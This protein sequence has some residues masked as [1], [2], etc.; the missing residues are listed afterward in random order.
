MPKDI[1][2]LNWDYDFNGL[3]IPRTAEIAESGLPFMVCPGTNGWLTHGTNLPNAIG[4][5]SQFA[6]AGRKWGAEGLLNTDWGDCGH[7][8]TLGVSLHGFAHGAAHSWNGRGVDDKTFTRTFCFH[9]FGQRDGKLAKAVE[10]LGSTYQQDSGH[11]CSLVEPLDASKD[12]GK[13]LDPVSPAQIWPQLQSG[14]DAANGGG[15]RNIISKLSNTAMWAVSTKGLGEFEKLALEEYA[16]AARMDVLACKRALAGKKLRAGKNVPSTEL[17][18]LA[19]ETQSVA[20]TFRTLWLARNRPSRLRD[21][22]KLFEM[23]AKE[24]LR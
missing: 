13:S 17:K 19:K 22:M 6:A 11:Y 4:N 2:M 5:V 16:L 1:D 15:L 24:C 23:A 3:R 18:Q 9:V 21:N 10:T 20:E 7:R 12:F 14:I 8:N